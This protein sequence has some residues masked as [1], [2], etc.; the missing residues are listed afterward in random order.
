[1]GHREAQ[2]S[3]SR[4]D[5]VLKFWPRWAQEHA[6]LVEIDTFLLRKG[7]IYREIYTRRPPRNE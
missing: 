5:A 3:V 1:M 7:L 4:A 2:R 6:K